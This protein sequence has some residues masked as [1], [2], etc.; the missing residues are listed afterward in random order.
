VGRDPRDKRDTPAVIQAVADAYLDNWGDPTIK[1]PH[2]TPCARL[3]GRIYT[4]TRNPDGNNC[5]MGA[6]PQKLKVTQRRYVIDETIGARR[7]SVCRVRLVF[8]LSGC[9]I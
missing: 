7:N 4:G 1:V 9:T 6:F 5:N 8:G 3:P 2:G